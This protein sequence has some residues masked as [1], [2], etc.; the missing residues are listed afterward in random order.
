MYTVRYRAKEIPQKDAKINLTIL[1]I[2]IALTFFFMFGLF[3]GH[4]NFSVIC[5]LLMFFSLICSVPVVIIIKFRTKKLEVETVKELNL[6]ADKNRLYCD[7]IHF[8][9]MYDEKNDLVHLYSTAATTNGIMVKVIDIVLLRE[10]NCG[11]LIFCENNGI[12]TKNA[13]NYVF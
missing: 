6:T 4:G 9:V 7:K 8:Y 11:F 10:D 12:D 13:H 5:M 2:W 1:M 3:F